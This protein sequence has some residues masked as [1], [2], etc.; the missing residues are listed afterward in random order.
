MKQCIS[1]LEGHSLLD[2][3]S[4]FGKATTDTDG[5]LTTERIPTQT[6]ANTFSTVMVV[7]K[8][9]EEKADCMPLPEHVSVFQWFFFNV[10]KIVSVASGVRLK[11][12]IGFCDSENTSFHMMEEAA[13]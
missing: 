9:T 8:A 3:R 7:K 13:I 1:R 4:L 5:G 11:G 12:C 2:P 6:L 10:A